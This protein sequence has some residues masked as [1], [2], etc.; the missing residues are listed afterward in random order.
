MQIYTCVCILQYHIFHHILLPSNWASCCQHW[1]TRVLSLFNA[2]SSRKTPKDSWRDLFTAGG[3]GVV[4]RADKNVTFE[5]EGKDGFGQSFCTL[6]TSE[7]NLCTHCRCIL[8]SWHQGD[9]RCAEGHLHSS[10]MLPKVSTE[11]Y[12]C[13]K[14][15]V[16]MKLFLLKDN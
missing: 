6:Q 12:R 14:N 4:G 9:G 3:P 15:E 10:P 13:G 8:N 11:P 1:C 2:C 5:Q 16:K 7:P